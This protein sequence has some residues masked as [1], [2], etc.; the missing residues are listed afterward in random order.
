MAIYLVQHGESV[1]KEVDPDRPLSDKGQNDVALVSAQLHNAGVQVVKIFHSGKTRARQTA[2][3]FAEQLNPERVTEQSGMKPNDNAAAFAALLEDNTMYV[4]HL[5]HL[6]RLVSFLT[7]DEE[8]ADV[9]RFSN[10]GVVCL[11]KGA[12]GYSVEW[13]ITPSLCR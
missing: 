7:A 3:L 1:V 10:S 9:I 6:A 2:E 8:D 11:G 13:Y 12:N 5:P 4:G